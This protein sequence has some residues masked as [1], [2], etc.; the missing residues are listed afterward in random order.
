MSCPQH[1]TG[2]AADTKLKYEF[3]KINE[4]VW[5]M[6]ST[7]EVM[8]NLGH[9]ITIHGKNKNAILWNGLINKFEQIIMVHNCSFGLYY[10]VL[11]I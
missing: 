1:E 10:S 5:I 3:E 2:S 9:G 8:A 11:I 4:I 7:M 6:M